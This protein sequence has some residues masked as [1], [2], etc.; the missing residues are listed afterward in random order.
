MPSAREARGRAAKTLVRYPSVAVVSRSFAVFVL[1]GTL[2]VA[3]G[4]C[5]G[6]CSL[7][8]ADCELPTG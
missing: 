2:N 8:A 7:A 6:A 5:L 1:N 4:T 3:R